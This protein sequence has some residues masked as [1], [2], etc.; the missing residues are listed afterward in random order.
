[1]LGFGRSAKPSLVV[2]YHGSMAADLHPPA[3]SAVAED[4]GV[5]V[6]PGPAPVGQPRWLG[7]ICPHLRAA[8]GT[9][10][11]AVPTREHRCWAVEP[12]AGLPTA[13]QQEL[14]LTEAHGG[15]ERFLRSRE[16]RT[17][18]LAEDQIE[19][20][21]LRSARFGPFVS[22]IPVAVESRPAGKELGGASGGTRRR[23][24]ALLVA[25]GV[26]LVGVVA[27]AVIFGGGRLPG[28]AVLVPSQSP[29]VTEAPVVPQS[30]V[31]APTAGP[32]S[33]PV[34]T[35]APTLAP[36]AAPTAQATATAPV[37]SQPPATP[38]P[39]PTATVRPTPSPEIARRYTV[40][41]GDTIRSIANKFG[42]KPRDL[43]A[44]NDIGDEVEVGQRLRIPARSIS[45]P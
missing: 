39:D 2:A 35:A 6:R 28:V 37:R 38:R 8:D 30:V 16:Q 7:T 1:L 20:G 44:V 41:V 19:V 18:A 29:A 21:R 45:E 42:L 3:G 14:C 31:P 33:T 9:W 11:S 40:K 10:R 17:A 36:T 23:V 4:I 32:V 22:T 13:T 26:V 34:A 27:L 15:C 12:A 25:G 24:P 5:A 43:R